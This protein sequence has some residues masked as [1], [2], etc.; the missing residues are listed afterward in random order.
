MRILV[1]DDQDL[2]RE[3]LVMFLKAQGLSDIAEVGTVDQAENAIAQAPDAFDLVLLDYDMPGMDG[4]NGL[5]RIRKAMQGR[6]VAILSGTASPSVARDAIEAGA[7]G[8]LPK[9]MGAKSLASNERKLVM[10]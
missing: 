7:R 4:L 5:A 10:P 6:P 1:A 9:T 8:F 2:I 3:T